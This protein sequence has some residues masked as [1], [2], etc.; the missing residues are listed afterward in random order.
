[1]W[2]KFHDQMPQ[3]PE[4]D[5]L[6]DGAFRLYVTAV[7]YGQA[8][9]TD[10]IVTESKTRRLTPNYDPSHLAELTAPSTNKNG[11]LFAETPDGYRIRNF[12]KYNKTREYWEQ[13]REAEAEKKRRWREK[14][15]RDTETGQF[16]TPKLRAIGDEE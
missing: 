13:R 11:P 10:G 3:D 8:E 6:S 14:V 12:E 2:V 7:F 9:L 16:Q 1:M 15:R 5:R 4:I